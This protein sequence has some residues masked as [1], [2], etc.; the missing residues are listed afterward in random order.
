MPLVLVLKKVVFG[1]LLLLCA[2][3]P[4]CCWGAPSA[5]SWHPGSRVRGN[6]RAHGATL[7][8][9]PLTTSSVSKDDGDVVAKEISEDHQTSNDNTHDHDQ[10][11]QQSIKHDDGDDDNV[12]LSNVDGDDAGGEAEAQKKTYLTTCGVAD[13]NEKIRITCEGNVTVKEIAWASYGRPYYKTDD[14]TTEAASQD[15]VVPS[16]FYKGVKD[17][18]T[19]QKLAVSNTCKEEANNVQ[20]T[21]EVVR[22]KCEGKQ[23]CTLEV[24]TNSFE[25]DPCFGQIK[26]I[27]VTVLS[28][29]GACSVMRLDKTRLA[30]LRDRPKKSQEEYERCANALEKTG[31]AIA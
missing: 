4:L 31:A 8:S 16:E 17:A 20:S 11:Q 18:K 9:S 19:C 1:L 28:E 23:A 27:A 13:E 6:R 3:A 5:P 7:R 2:C 12:G 10:K 26:R 25:W 14:E 22:N 29:R 15:A 24:G 30:P 21:M